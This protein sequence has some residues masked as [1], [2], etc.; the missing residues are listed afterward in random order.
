MIT[1]PP[2]AKIGMAGSSKTAINRRWSSARRQS[3]ARRNTASRRSN[4][5]SENQPA[6]GLASISEPVSL[7][8]HGPP[9][10]PRWTA[11]SATR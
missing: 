3:D 2:I 10:T 6:A 4:P 8:A 7:T 9:S 11:E 1:T 5:P